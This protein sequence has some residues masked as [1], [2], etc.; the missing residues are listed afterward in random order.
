[1]KS[2]KPGAAASAR[3]AARGGRHGYTGEGWQA[4]KKRPH[5]PE[6]SGSLGA[7][8]CGPRLC[9][10]DDSDDRRGSQRVPG[11]H[12]ASFP[13]SVSGDECGGGVSARAAAQ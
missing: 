11:R 7:V 4:E 1:M 9:Q 3:R 10:Y 2:A 13:L 6:Y 12:D 5:T 8:F